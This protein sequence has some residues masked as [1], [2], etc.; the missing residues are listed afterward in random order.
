[1]LKKGI[2]PNSATWPVILAILIGPPNCELSPD[3][4]I[5]EPKY[6]KEETLTKRG[7][8]RASLR[9]FSGGLNTQ[10]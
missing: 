8:T 3:P 4:A 10:K 2:N 7:A 9:L 1:M 5:I 6:F